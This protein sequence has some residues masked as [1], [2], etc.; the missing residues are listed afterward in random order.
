MI[1]NLPI[2]IA[3]DDNDIRR[4]LETAF[5]RIGYPTFGAGD[6]D[7]AIAIAESKELSAIVL[8]IMMPKRSGILVLEHIRTKLEFERSIFVLTGN[9]SKR[10]ESNANVFDISGYFCKPFNVGLLV[11]QIDKQIQFDSEMA[12]TGAVD[13]AN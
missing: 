4:T 13:F 5:Q 12:S 11:S 2:L 8:D 6:G 3:D 10:L 9:A 1:E 7:L